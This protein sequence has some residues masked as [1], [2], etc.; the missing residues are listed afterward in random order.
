MR[1]CRSC[2]QG[3]RWYRSC[4]QG[5]EATVLCCQSSIADE[6]ATSVVGHVFLLCTGALD[7][8]A[9]LLSAVSCSLAVCGAGQDPAITLTVVSGACV[10]PRPRNLDRAMPCDV[11]DAGPSAPPR[12]RH[13]PAEDVG[14]DRR[15]AIAG[16]PGWQTRCA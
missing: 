11:P 15:L 10:C 8:S 14:D 16:G 9:F 1:W 4:G 13:A 6:A 12:G 3:K 7:H 5:R 2:G